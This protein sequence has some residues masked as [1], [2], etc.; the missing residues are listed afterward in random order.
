MR[1]PEDQSLNSGSRSYSYEEEEY[2]EERSGSLS[3]SRSFEGERSGPGNE[4]GVVERRHRRRRLLREMPSRRSNSSLYSALPGLESYDDGTA[5]SEEDGSTMRSPT[6]PRLDEG[7]SMD[8][9]SEYSPSSPPLSPSFLSSSMSRT[10][11]ESVLVQRV[12]RIGRALEQPV[13][14][15]MVALA[16]SR[17]LRLLAALSNTVL[18]T[19]P[20][21]FGVSSEV[22]GMPVGVEVERVLPDGYPAVPR[23][24]QE[25]R[26]SLP[27]RLVEQPIKQWL[28]WRGIPVLSEVM[29]GE[30]GQRWTAAAG[31]VSESVR[32]LR[33]ASKGDVEVWVT[34]SPMIPTAVVLPVL[35]LVLL[36]VG[37]SWGEWRVGKQ[38]R[39]VVRS[40]MRDPARGEHAGSVPGLYRE[41]SPIVA[42]SNE[43]YSD[44][45]W[46]THAAPLPEKSVSRSPSAGSVLPPV[47][48]PAPVPEHSR[49]PVEEPEN[50][51]KE[52]I[53][54]T[55]VGRA[56]LMEEVESGGR[57]GTPVMDS[58]LARSPRMNR[59]FTVGTVVAALLGVP[60][61]A[62]VNKVLTASA[63]YGCTKVLL[64]LSAQS[65]P[66]VTL[67]SPTSVE[68]T[69]DVLRD[70]VELG[71]QR[72]MTV[73][74]VLA[75]AVVAE[76]VHM[77]VFKH[78]P[79]GIYVFSAA[80]GVAFEEV[81]KA[82]SQM[83]YTFEHGP[84]DSIPITE[85][86]SGRLQYLARRG[87]R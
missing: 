37:Q 12:K 9:Y 87:V 78:P 25:L 26:A 47:A 75:R 83:V 34:S 43:R 20:T 82:A 39:S 29:H 54:K 30:T 22:D 48:D 3:L 46:M 81:T 63:A 65:L 32:A 69:S 52:F 35:T 79:S 36:R 15:G 19:R 68:C 66:R 77:S 84:L 60:T 33:R 10:L 42:G 24:M 27:V 86:F 57:G 4:G 76:A 44:S 38:R 17:V 62:E 5:F 14:F 16:G 50:V 56:K 45:P 21:G 61:L 64:P 55:P 40:W 59:M 28:Q 80:T 73:V 67:S 31:A 71:E 18:L 2:S 11:F 7:S 6:P 58:P 13:L 49:T 74:G 41:I 8:E 70:V 1:S 85:C 51:A 72:Q 23:W 53:V